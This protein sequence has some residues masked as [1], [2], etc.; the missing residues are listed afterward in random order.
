LIVQKF[1]AEQAAWKM[2]A[3][4]RAREKDSLPNRQ[5]GEVVE[6][7]EL[8]A[9][10]HYKTAVEIKNAAEHGNLG[11]VNKG[12]QELI[13]AMGKS[14]K[15]ALRSFLELLMMHIIKWKTQPLKRSLGWKRTIYNARNEI[16]EI[17]EETPSLPDEVIKTMWEKS[18]TRAMLDAE[19]EMEQKTELTELTWDAVFKQE[20]DI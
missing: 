20:Y 2:I 7:Q 6:W 17:Q 19:A 5:Q 1:T 4:F 15:R 3:R 18:F 16:E 11:E 14:E 12:I 8:A 10:S 9:E 13:E